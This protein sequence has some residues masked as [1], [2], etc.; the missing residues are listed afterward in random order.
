M[1]MLGNKH[2]FVSN[3]YGFYKKLFGDKRGQLQ[4]SLE[5]INNYL[6]ETLKGLYRYKDLHQ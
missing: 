3:T 5:E 2:N 4:C 6:Q 1:I